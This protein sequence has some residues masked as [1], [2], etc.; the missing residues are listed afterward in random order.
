MRTVKSI[1]LKL[2]QKVSSKVGQAPC[3]L[4]QLVEKS[5]EPVAITLFDYDQLSCE[6]KQI[7][8][9]S[10][11]KHLK[12]TALNS[13]INIDGIHDT[14]LVAEI[15]QIFGIH[16]LVLEDILNPRQ[17]IKIDLYD[18]YVFIVLK[19][20]TYSAESDSFDKENVSLILGKQFLISFQEKPGDT[21]DVIR[22]RIRGED[23]RARR[24]GC[25]YLA[26]RLIDSIVDHYYVVLEKYGEQIEQFE[27]E[28][29]ENPDSALVNNI[30]LLKRE[31]LLFLRAV[32]P[33]SEVL[34]GMTKE[35]AVLITDDTRVFLR[36]VND[37]FMQVKDTANSFRD[38]A[39]DMLDGYLSMMSH[40]MN[41]VMQVL[42][43][44][45]AIFIPLTFIAGVYGMNFEFM[46]E[47]KFKYMYPLVWLVMC[48]VAVAMLVYF[49]RKKWF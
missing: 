5:A 47:L 44:F 48:G 35:H 29:S 45:A 20:I 27:I 41:E 7:E 15:G 36:D 11:L 30:Q 6:E 39:A 26:Y 43:I 32:L 21:F 49:K 10:E 37:H 2:Y 13:W 22:K 18:D 33:L 38:L 42:T 23:S 17:R 9:A 8:A 4:T 34:S 16:P 14:N 3:T 46:P 19:M 24:S 25:D 1:P 12:E 40:K 31:L 28:L